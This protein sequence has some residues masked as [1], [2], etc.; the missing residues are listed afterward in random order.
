[1]TVVFLLQY[2]IEYTPLRLIET[3][4]VIASGKKTVYAFKQGHLSVIK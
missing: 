2:F 4:T 1:M 3:H